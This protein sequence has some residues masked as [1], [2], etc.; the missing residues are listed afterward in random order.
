MNTIWR[1]SCRSAH[2]HSA[3]WYTHVLFPNLWLPKLKMTCNQ[4]ICLT[5]RFGRHK[6]IAKS[7]KKNFKFSLVASLRSMLGRGLFSWQK[8]INFWNWANF[9]NMDTLVT[10][11]QIIS[12]FFCFHNEIFVQKCTEF[13]KNDSSSLLYIL[14]MI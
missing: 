7:S 4:N 10:L 6:K 5:I 14:K 2:Q 9:L 12:V 13:I 1:L 8:I 11:D 3:G